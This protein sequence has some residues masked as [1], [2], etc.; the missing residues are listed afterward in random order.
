MIADGAPLRISPAGLCPGKLPKNRS[1]PSEQSPI[2]VH[3]P[4]LGRTRSRVH[5]CNLSVCPSHSIGCMNILRSIQRLKTALRTDSW[6]ALRLC[7]Q[8][9]I[10]RYRNK[11]RITITCS[12]TLQLFRLLWPLCEPTQ[13][14]RIAAV[15]YASGLNEPST[16]SWKPPNWSRQKAVTTNL[17][18]TFELRLLPWPCS[19]S[20]NAPQLPS[21]LPAVIRS[22]P[23]SEPPIYTSCCPMEHLLVRA[24]TSIRYSTK[25]IRLCWVTL[26]TGSR[27]PIAHGCCETAV[28]LPLNGFF[29]CWNFSGTTSRSCRG[30]LRSPSLRNFRDSDSS[31]AS[32]IW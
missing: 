27:I 14:S 28:S 17:W 31:P 32:V 26:F 8:A 18:I 6:I 9:R 4:A 22:L 2:F 1:S 19:R 24:I 25:E 21:I 5:G 13:V 23:A 15:L 11:L 7:S 10:F 30:S 29:Q 20:F 12:G 3:C 16:I